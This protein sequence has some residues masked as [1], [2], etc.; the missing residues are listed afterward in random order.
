[1]NFKLKSYIVNC[2]SY[3]IKKFLL[4]LFGILFFSIISKAQSWSISGKV[5]DALTRDPVDYAYVTATGDSAFAVTDAEGNYT[6]YISSSAKT[7]F[8]LADGYEK[9]TIAVK[10]ITRM[11]LNVE[12]TANASQ[13]ATEA[14]KAG[15]KP[16]EYLVEKVIENRD[17]NDPENNDY[18]S[19][20]TYEKIEFDLANVSDKIKEKKIMKPFAFMFDNMD[21]VTTNGKPFLPFFFTETLSDVYH[22]HKPK[23]K[24]EIVI[25]SK[26]AGVENL[27]LIQL[28]K[29]IYRDITIYDNYINVFGKSFISP[30]SNEGLKHYDYVIRDTTIIDGKTCYKIIF[31]AK[32]KFD[33]TF[34]GEFWFHDTTFAVQR[35]TMYLNK[36]AMINF[37]DDFKFVKVFKN[38][39]DN[40][41][42]PD[43]EQLVVQFS[44]REKGMS[45]IGRKS[46]YYAD[47]KINMPPADSVFKITSTIRFDPMAYDQTN[48]FWR[49]ERL[50]KLTDREKD[51]YDLVDTLKKLPAFQIYVGSVVVALTGY[52]PYGK[53]D[54]GPY[55][56][57]ITNNTLEGVRFRFGGRT[58]EKFSTRW[59]FEGYGAYGTLDGTFK[60]MGGIRYT[61]KRKPFKAIGFQYKND[62]VQPGLYE[63]YFKDE[64]WIVILFKRNPSDKMCK[65]ESQKVYYDAAYR[66]GLSFR[67]QYLKNH[68]T[69]VGNI[70][71]DYYAN[72]SRTVIKHDLHTSEFWIS[73]RYSYGEKFIEKK[74]KR[75]SLGSDNPVFQLNYIKGLRNFL[76]GEFSYSKIAARVT[77]KLNLFPYGHLNF[78]IEAGK[79]F[80]NVPY[81]LLYVHRGNESRLFDY[82]AFNL[83]NHYEFVSDR[84][85]GASAEHH[86]DGFALRRIPLIRKLDWREIVSARILFGHLSQKNK[87]ILFDP[88][89]VSNIRTTPYI[90]AGVG[91]ENILKLIRIDALWRL[92]Y[93][94][95]PEASNFGVRLSLQ[96]LF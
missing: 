2:T 76:E 23:Q 39:D 16:V 94:D 90:E 6:I 67:L 41:W 14:R 25:A 73:A 24:R 46:Q 59:Q 64:G 28:L 61:I 49:E 70:N 42:V 81:P 58:N 84:Y 3:I 9:F 50:E 31:S 5:I 47:T 20:R 95:N 69:T 13:V 75:Y 43:R 68:Y 86:F 33:L 92:T 54:Y 38:I 72:D 45:I 15:E 27:T 4:V 85:A 18:F 7:V 55:Y 22:E 62:V 74:Y 12:L 87:E 82:T 51:I 77:D 35:I 56:H 53:I 32:K 52:V 96:L 91:L 37:V 11:T 83:M 79:V 71:F 1:L 19:Y 36:D 29:D 89:N 60:Y 48:K 26:T 93:P 80:G 21:S 44:N 17:K 34:N 30:V 78:S 66:S 88:A 63:G 57:L 40:K 10:N 65:V 8:V